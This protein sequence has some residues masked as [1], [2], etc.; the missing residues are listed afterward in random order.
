MIKYEITDSYYAEKARYVKIAAERV[1]PLAR[2]QKA[3]ARLQRAEKACAA[4]EADRRVAVTRLQAAYDA[5]SHADRNPR[6]HIVDQFE[7]GRP[8]RRAAESFDAAT[9]ELRRALKAAGFERHA[10]QVRPTRVALEVADEVADEVAAAY[11]RL[12]ATVTSRQAWVRQD[13]AAVGADLEHLE[14]LLAVA[15]GPYYQAPVAGGC[16]LAA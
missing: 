8:A 16:R 4:A 5:K 12:T 9:T 10:G 11:A 1:R 7:A 13:A 2:V 3:I 15:A 14:G 6:Q